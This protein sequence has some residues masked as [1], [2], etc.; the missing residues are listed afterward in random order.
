VLQM[1]KKD[2]HSFATE[3]ERFIPVEQIVFFFRKSDYKI[4]ILGISF[5][6][7]AEQLRNRLRR[8]IPPGTYKDGPEVFICHDHEDREYASRMYDKLNTAGLRPWLDKEELRGG[9]KWD[10]EIKET[11]NKV[12]Y[13]VV[14]N[15][16]RMIAKVEGYVFEEIKCALERQRRFQDELFR[17]IIPVIIDGS[18]L[19][20]KLESIQAIKMKDVENME[21]LILTIKSDFE[22]RRAQ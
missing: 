19:L 16:Q 10:N 9:D 20:K 13:F 11:I 14:L 12:D 4:N 22:A 7:F 6:E 21:D 15:S 8:S 2:T 5:S 17:F 3:E 1:R 18:P